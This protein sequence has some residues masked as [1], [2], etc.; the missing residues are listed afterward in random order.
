MV[1]GDR[2]PQTSGNAST[3]NILLPGNKGA[4]P[5]GKTDTDLFGEVGSEQVVRQNEWV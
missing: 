2:L 4:D 5:I 3:G 1:H